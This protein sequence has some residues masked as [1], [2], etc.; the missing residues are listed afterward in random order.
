MGSKNQLIGALFL[1]LANIFSFIMNSYHWRFVIMS[2]NEN[3]R[4]NCF[5]LQGLDITIQ[6][7]DVGMFGSSYRVCPETTETELNVKTCFQVNGTKDAPVKIQSVLP[8]LSNFKASCAM[9]C[10]L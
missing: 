10:N 7:E 2:T 6:R 9:L 8:D 3:F 1:G 4:I 5:F